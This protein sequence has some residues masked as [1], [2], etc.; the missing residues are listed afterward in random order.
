[1]KKKGLEMVISFIK[2]ELSKNVSNCNSRRKVNYSSK[3]LPVTPS[4]D[5]PRNNFRTK[6]SASIVFLNANDIQS[7]NEPN[8]NGKDMYYKW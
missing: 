7:R 3:F 8:L 1:M 2:L 5:I 6:F 4:K